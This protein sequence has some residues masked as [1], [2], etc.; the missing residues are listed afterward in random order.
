MVGGL[1][2]ALWASSAV[3]DPCTAIPE[4]GPLPSYLARGSTFS[5]RVVYIGD[6]DSLCV[7]LGGGPE[8]WV[9]VRL[10]DFYA[11]ELHDAGGPEAKAALSK[12]ALSRN[13]NCLAGRRSY[14]RVVARCEIGGRSI[15]DSLRS[16]G[17]REGGRGQP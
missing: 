11:P 12:L 5:G 10:E 15:G 1:A 16:M 17:I 9:E 2:L 3:A 6:G 7:S 8:T 14:D 4:R 13:A